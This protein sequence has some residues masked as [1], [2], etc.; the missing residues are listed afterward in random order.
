MT[1]ADDVET[2][3][4]TMQNCGGGRRV[5]LHAAQRIAA[6]VRPEEVVLCDAGLSDEPADYF[7]GSVVVF[8]ATRV[9]VADLEKEADDD[10]LARVRARAW[11]RSALDLVEML[12]SDDDWEQENPDGTLPSG[13]GLRLS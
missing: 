10:S 11:G 7:T 6:L 12:G 9:I 3:R 5:P 2:I 4:A 8:T 1:Y 13:G